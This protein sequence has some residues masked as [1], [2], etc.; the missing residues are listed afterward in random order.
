M[1]SFVCKEVSPRFSTGIVHI[2]REKSCIR[3]KLYEENSHLIARIPL[4]SMFAYVRV[5]ACVLKVF[6]I[7]RFIASLVHTI[8]VI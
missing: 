5:S 7:F 3:M 2:V 1:N 6:S 4:S 8:L